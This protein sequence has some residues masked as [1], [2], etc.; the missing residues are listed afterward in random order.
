MTDLT[1][2]LVQLDGLGPNPVE[3][4]KDMGDGSH[5]MVVALTTAP[6]PLETTIAQGATVS[7]AIDLGDAT[8]CGI[9]W[10]AAMTLTSATCT[11]QVSADGVAYKA[12]KRDDGSALTLTGL[13]QD[14]DTSFGDIFT[15]FYGVRY[16]KLVIARSTCVLDLRPEP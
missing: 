7:A 6:A 3:K 12:L 8:I 16:L 9:G 2:V 15:H 1:R 10:P 14:T 5:A 11:F 4:L 13:A